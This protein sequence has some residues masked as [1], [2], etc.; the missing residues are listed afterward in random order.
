MKTEYPLSTMARILFPKG[1]SKARIQE[2]NE[3][4]AAASEMS[5]RPV[6][7]PHKP[8]FYYDAQKPEEQPAPEP[9]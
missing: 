9:E 5:F 7:P 8:P 2:I 6:L 3:M 1:M 4:L